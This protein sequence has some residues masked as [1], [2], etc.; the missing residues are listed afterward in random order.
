M[1]RLDGALGRWRGHGVGRSATV[2]AAVVAAALVAVAG[3][4][5]GS[6]STGSQAAFWNEEHG[7]TVAD[8][9]PG[10]TGD[11]LAERRFAPVPSSGRLGFTLTETGLTGPPFAAAGIVRLELANLTTADRWLALVDAAAIDPKTYASSSGAIPAPAVVAGRYRI[12]AGASVDVV[13]PLSQGRYLVASVRADRLAVET[14]AP[15]RVSP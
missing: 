11:E 7:R 4:T 14:A 3:Q 8:H 12:P 15:L 2:L 13:V 6:A 10:V 1:E 5:S 9:S